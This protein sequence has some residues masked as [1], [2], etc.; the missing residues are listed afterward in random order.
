MTNPDNLIAKL[1]AEIA[2]AG[3]DGSV[4]TERILVEARDMI[5]TLRKERDA[6][7]RANFTLGYN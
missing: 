5:R 1:N 7:E 2:N 4:I 3:R 6:S